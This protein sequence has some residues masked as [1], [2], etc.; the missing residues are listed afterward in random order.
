MS[1]FL[2]TRFGT[3]NGMLGIFTEVRYRSFDERYI[4]ILTCTHASWYGVK[5]LPK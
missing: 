5:Y 2:L 4:L 3:I 1:L